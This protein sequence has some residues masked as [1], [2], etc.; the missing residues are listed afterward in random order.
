MYF[1]E[2]Q[3]SHLEAMIKAVVDAH[4]STHIA[5]YHGNSEMI[6]LHATDIEHSVRTEAKKALVRG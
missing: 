2:E 5:N 4:I 3:F 1:T 6:A